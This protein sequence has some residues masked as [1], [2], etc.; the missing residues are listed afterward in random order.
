V[1]ATRSRI[2]AQTRVLA[3]CSYNPPTCAKLLIL[4][5]SNLRDQGVGGSNPLAPTIFP[6]KMEMSVGKN[7]RGSRGFTLVLPGAPYGRVWQGRALL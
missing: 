3:Y 1:T 6:Y 5:A 7:L 2:A 4:G